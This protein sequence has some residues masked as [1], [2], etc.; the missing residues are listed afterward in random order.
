MLSELSLHSYRCLFESL[1]VEWT[2]EWRFR[3]ATVLYSSIF[4][5]ILNAYAFPLI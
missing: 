4:F 2:S 5:Y 1:E 3:I